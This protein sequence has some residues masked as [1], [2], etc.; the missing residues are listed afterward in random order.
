GPTIGRGFIESIVA[1]IN[2]LEPDLIAITGDLVDG[3][4]EELAEHVAALAKLKA[5]DGV[6]FVTGTHEYY[7]GADEWTAHLRTLG[8]RVLANEHVRIRGDE[9]FDLAGIDD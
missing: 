4:V 3:S 5:K 2:A 7:S 6:Y 1:R 8:V 9:G